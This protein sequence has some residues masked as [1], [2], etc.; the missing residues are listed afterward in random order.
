MTIVASLQLALGHWHIQTKH[1]TLGIADPVQRVGALLG[2]A[3]VILHLAV[4]CV[5]IK[6][7]IIAWRRLMRNLMVIFSE[8]FW[9]RLVFCQLFWLM[10]VF[11]Q[12]LR[13]VVVLRNLRIRILMMLMVDDELRTVLIVRRVRQSKGILTESW[14]LVW[15]REE[16]A[17]ARN[18]GDDPLGLTL[19]DDDQEEE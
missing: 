9:L 14:I 18:V 7:V 3:C 8:L 10:L 16:V 13:L 2:E 11:C 4:S 15:I 12:L 19:A 6:T 5:L 17:H 1:L